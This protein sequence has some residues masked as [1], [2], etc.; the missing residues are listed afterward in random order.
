[1][2]SGSREDPPDVARAGFPETQSISL[3]PGRF[4]RHTWIAPISVVG[5]ALIV[6]A[7][8][9]ASTTDVVEAVVVVCALVLLSL[10]LPLYYRRVRT[11][12]ADSRGF[13]SSSDDA[14]GRT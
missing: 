1:M 7:T 14:S 3:A 13:E 10:L 9:E 12:V 5:L 6:I 2:R 11:I 8:P 4:Y